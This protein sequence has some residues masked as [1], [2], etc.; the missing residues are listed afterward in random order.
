MEPTERSRESCMHQ[1]G[2]VDMQH[3]THGGKP[4]SHQPNESNKLRGC[5]Y[6]WFF[7]SG[8]VESPSGF[9]R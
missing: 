2:K 3:G 6:A 5:S 9:P 4:P 1:R 8:E 7:Q